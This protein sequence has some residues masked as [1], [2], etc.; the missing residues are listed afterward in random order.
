M[1]KRDI[2]KEIYD[3]KITEDEGYEIFDAYLD[4]CDGWELL[5]KLCLSRIEY[6][7]YAHGAGLRDLS[8]WRYDGWPN[9]CTI[10]GKVIAVDKYGWVP[11][12]DASGQTVLQHIA[13]RPV[14]EDASD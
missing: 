13:C 12:E 2:L 8:A 10:C 5:E 11:E 14:L 9:R 6:T 4:D 7:G 3:G 1:I